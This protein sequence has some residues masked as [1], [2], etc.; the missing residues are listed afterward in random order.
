MKKIA[1]AGLILAVA[2]SAAQAQ[3]VGQSD[4]VGLAL[5]G[6]FGSTTQSAGGD[7]DG[8]RWMF[9]GTYGI[10]VSDG[11]IAT[12]GMRY[13]FGTLVVPGTIVGA[14]Y[15]S[16]SP[17]AAIGFDLDGLMPYA[18]VAMNSSSI[19]NADGT[20]LMYGAGL[21]S[22]FG[23]MFNFFVEFTTGSTSDYSGADL[24]QTDIDLGIKLKL[25]G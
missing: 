1:A 20:V 9:G 7:V 18:T 24:T 11:V 8:G 13:S 19:G 25:G 21:E 12:V 14:D 10:E 23:Q 3:S 16:L 17:R 2:A 4:F 6:G 15:S 22:E 5:E